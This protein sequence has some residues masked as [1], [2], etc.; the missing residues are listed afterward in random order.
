MKWSEKQ[1]RTSKKM[2]ERL[3]EFTKL[4]GKRITAKDCCCIPTPEIARLY[5]FVRVFCPYELLEL[6]KPGL[7]IINKEEFMT[8]NYTGVKMVPDTM[9]KKCYIVQTKHRKTKHSLHFNPDLH[10][11]LLQLPNHL[12][13]QKLWLSTIADKSKKPD[14]DWWYGLTYV[15]IEN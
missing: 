10:E 7:D 13:S 9:A 8:S 4:P 15:L 1:N 11:V 5:E 14:D 3:F 2:L 6:K 12:H